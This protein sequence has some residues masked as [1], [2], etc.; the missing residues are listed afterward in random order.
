MTDYLPTYFIPVVVV[1]VVVTVI[2]RHDVTII[3]PSPYH[4]TPPYH[5]PF[6]LN[7]NAR[8]KFVGQY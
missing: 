1:V 7:R 6:F 5:H 4:Q 3:Q 2:S 8:I